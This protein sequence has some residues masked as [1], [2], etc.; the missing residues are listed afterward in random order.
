ME[1]KTDAIPLI[2]D[3]PQYASLSPGSP[4]PRVPDSCQKA[5]VPLPRG[6][7]REMVSEYLDGCRKDLFQLRAAL[8]A[9]DYELARRVGHQMKGT[10]DP[11]GFP[12]LTKIGIS[13][14][15]TAAD[16]AAE[17]E[18]HIDRLEAVLN[19]VEI[20]PEGDSLPGV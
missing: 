17:L 13:I 6:L 11:Y 15:R 16:R 5:V 7:P 19:A 14:E 12:D 9:G 3:R 20:E 2:E 4:Q 18:S 10:G 8:A 1:V